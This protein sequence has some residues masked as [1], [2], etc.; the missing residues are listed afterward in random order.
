MALAVFARFRVIRLAGLLR[1]L[2]LPGHLPLFLRPS[3]ARLR[4]LALREKTKEHRK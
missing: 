4:P 1:G 3:M 2:R